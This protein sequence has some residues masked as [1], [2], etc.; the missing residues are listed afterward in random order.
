MARLGDIT[1][2]TSTVCPGT[3]VYMPPEAVQD[4]PVYTEKIDCFSFGVITLQILTRRFPN[5]G[6]RLQEVELSH[7][8]LGT[9]RLLMQI[10]E[11]NRRHNHISKVD[12]DHPLLSVI[13]DCLKDKDNERPS[14]HQLCDK[15]AD[16]K[17]MDTYID[18]TRTVQDKDEVIQELTSRVEEKDRTI[19]SKDKEIQQ[20]RLQ[21][22]KYSV[23]EKGEREQLPK[24]EQVMTQSE[25]IVKWRVHQQSD[26]QCS[27]AGSEGKELDNVIKLKWIKRRTTPFKMYRSCDAVVNG[28]TLYLRAGGTV[29]IYSYDVATDSWSRLPDCAKQYCSITVISGCLTTVGGNDSNELFSLMGESI[30]R[31]WTKLYPPMPTKRRGTSALCTE[32]TLIVGWRRDRRRGSAVNGRGDGYRES[33]VV[34]CC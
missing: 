16:L 14:A 18:S 31:R 9:G 6:D 26:E 22:Q 17:E 27:K 30:R 25:L 2:F 1:R 34:H 21:L 8:G 3:D 10:P 24:Q 29:E 5:P 4:K 13:L 32:T 7:P 11:V 15:I 28:N 23:Q 12:P 20:L 19:L 33:P